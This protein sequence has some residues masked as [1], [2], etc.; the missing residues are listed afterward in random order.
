MGGRMERSPGSLHSVRTTSRR[1]LVS[2]YRCDDMICLGVL[3]T[4]L[5]GTLSISRYGRVHVEVLLAEG[6]ELTRPSL[7]QATE[8]KRTAN[9]Q[10]DGRTPCLAEQADKNRSSI[11]VPTPHA[12]PLGADLEITGCPP[13]CIDAR[14]GEEEACLVL[15]WLP[16]PAWTRTSSLRGWA[17]TG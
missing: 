3:R 8:H 7:Q 17:W 14:S 16:T 2:A 6:F 10:R 1:C 15:S 5:C 11:N 9:R 13:I 4:A 12:F